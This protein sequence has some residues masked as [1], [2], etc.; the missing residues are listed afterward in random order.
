MSCRIKYFDVFLIG[1][2]L[3]YKDRVDFWNKKN[4][5]RRETRV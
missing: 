4:L 3:D 2:L 1:D 5:L